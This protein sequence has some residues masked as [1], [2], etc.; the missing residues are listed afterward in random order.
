MVPF[1]FA[2]LA[3]RRTSMATK[4]NKKIFLMPQTLQQPMHKAK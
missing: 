2:P 4:R 3:L 1:P